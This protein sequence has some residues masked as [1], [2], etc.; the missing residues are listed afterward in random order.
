[1]DFLPREIEQRFKR[2][3]DRG[4]SILL[5]GPRQTGKTTLVK[6]LNADL[7]LNLAKPSTRQAYEIR[8]FVL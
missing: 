3:L 5:L 7:Y 8:V 4:K 2:A 1:M 6:S